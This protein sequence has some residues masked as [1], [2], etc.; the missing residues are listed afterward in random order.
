MGHTFP[1][2][3]ERL[4]AWAFG[5]CGGASAFM[6]PGAS[7]PILCFAALTQIKSAPDQQKW[8]LA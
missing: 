3:I 7:N 4:Q 6:A 1:E 2:W 8:P 5:T